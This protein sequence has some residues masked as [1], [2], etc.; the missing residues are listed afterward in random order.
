MSED[1]T[2]AVLFTL[3]IAAEESAEALYRG[4]AAK[5]SCYAEVADFW[6]QYAVEE[7]GHALWLM[8]LRDHLDAERLAAPAD[9]LV[10][11]N[12]YRALRL[13][14]E[15]A[16]ARVHNVEDAYQLANDVESSETNA[17]FYFL[18]TNFAYNDEVLSFLQ[19]LLEDHVARLMYAFP[20]RFRDRQSRLAVKAQH[21]RA[22]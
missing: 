11:E 10:L 2:V 21:Q 7:A 6:R 18:V 19:S 14:V 3:A 4:L 22:A 13:S 8:R 12:A 17:V 1:A 9:P 5:F 15:T 16:L 20:R